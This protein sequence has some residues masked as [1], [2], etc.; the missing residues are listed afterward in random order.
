MAL[1]P[2]VLAA[3]LDGETS[4]Y[5]L[6]KTFA[7]SPSA[8]TSPQPRST[9]SSVLRTLRSDRDEA[10]FLREGGR[11]GPYLTCLRGPAFE[12]GNRDRYREAITAL[13]ERK[14]AR[15]GHRAPCRPR[16]TAPGRATAPLQRSHGEAP[17]PAS[18]LTVS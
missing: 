18:Q 12:R 8:P 14:D 13:T 5:E 10:G 17:Y 9:C 1:R 11:I 4:G 2:A 15:A 3:L 16:L 6:A 7:D